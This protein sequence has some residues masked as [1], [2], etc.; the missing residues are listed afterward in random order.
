MLQVGHPLTVAQ[1]SPPGLTWTSDNPFIEVNNDGRIQASA[2]HL[3]A[4]ARA[5]ITATSTD[6]RVVEEVSV[7]CEFEVQF[8][9]RRTH[10]PP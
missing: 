7:H 5:K 1:N 9:I 2:D 8:S 10:G 3:G 6:H 4:D